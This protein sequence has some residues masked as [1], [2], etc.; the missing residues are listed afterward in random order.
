M[1]RK[2]RVSTASTCGVE[3]EELIGNPV[4][5]WRIA[6]VTGAIHVPIQKHFRFAV[7]HDRPL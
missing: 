2:N 3:V 1:I 4:L 6:S 5:Q 7:G